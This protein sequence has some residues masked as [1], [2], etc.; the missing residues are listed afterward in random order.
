[1]GVLNF[2]SMATVVFSNGDLN[3][4]NLIVSFI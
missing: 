4:V 3:Y 2:A 1:V